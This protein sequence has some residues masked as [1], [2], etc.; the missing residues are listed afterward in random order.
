MP[1]NVRLEDVFKISGIP[2][3]T[4]VEPQK[5]PELLLNLRTPGRGLVVEGPSGIG[6]TTAVET[7]LGKLV[8]GSLI[9]RLSARKQEDVEMIEMLPSIP[10]AGTVLVDDFHKLDVGVRTALADY[11]KT[12]ADTEDKTTKVVVL[13]I[14]RAGDSLVNLA[15]D[16]VNR[17]DV[18]RF[19]NEPNAKIEE[20]IRKGE[21]SL[22]IDINVVSEIVDAVQGSFYLTQML[23][24]EICLQAHIL[25][26][27][28]EKVCT[29]V[30][31]EGVRARVWERLGMTFKNRCETFCRGTRLRKEG[32][33]PYLHVLNW[34]ASGKSWTL[35]LREELRRQ[36]TLRGS[37]S[38][39]V[40]KGFLKD[41]VNS[42]DE[43]RQVLHYDHW[44]DQLTVDDPQFLYYIKIIP[45]RQFAKDIGYLAVDFDR[46]YDFALSFAG[47]D[48]DVAEALF[49]E[50][51]K[52][53][54][55]VFY[56][57]NEQH[58]ILAEDVEEYL[59]PIYQT[60][61][62]FVIVLLGPDYP[63]RIWTKIESDEFKERLH[64]GS[65]IPVWFSNAPIGI[66][67]ET[68][69]TGGLIFDRSNDL[70]KQISEMSELL[71]RKLSETRIS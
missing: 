5:Y 53:E 11:M 35:D 51:T 26:K 30:S 67:D 43:I 10:K 21:A 32:R 59:K 49:K 48:M 38:Q 71:L 8:S 31:F 17:I 24:R 6:K 39:V 54:V 69:R 65:V 70:N 37:V 1:E 50:L 61:A 42:T 46:R 57:K 9:Q 34:L 13:G 63:K 66:F 62:Q 40:D 41:L 18:I 4:F 60:E 20:L 47:S 16:L 29:D 68:S 19:E 7:A 28:P 14:N 45:W 23:C 33:A 64:D 36:P 56:D 55:E 3:Y 2:T 12:L 44:S 25:E 22:N 27:C 58:R 52:N 15:P